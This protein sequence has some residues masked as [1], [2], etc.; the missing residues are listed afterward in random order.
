MKISIIQHD[1]VRKDLKGNLDRAEQLILSAEKSDLYVL[2][3]MFSTGFGMKPEKIAET[4][5]GET[6]QWMHRMAETTQAAIAGSVAINENG[7]FYNRFYFIYPDGKEIHYDKRHLF[8]YAK[9]DEHYTPGNERV[10]LEYKGVRILLQVCYDLRFPVFSRNCNDFDLML[11]TANWPDVRI[12]AW[13]LLLKARA[14]ENQCYVAAVNRCGADLSGEYEGHSVILNP[15]GKTLAQ[16][17]LEE[18]T[19][20]TLELDMEKLQQFRKDFP[21]LNDADDFEL[22]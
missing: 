21:V 15:F 4:P 16:C 8:S 2:P 20:A 18:N 5:D 13:D 19:S 6:L 11:Y 10:V 14:V 22:K 7:K 9:E 1:I 3:E 12:E 17:T